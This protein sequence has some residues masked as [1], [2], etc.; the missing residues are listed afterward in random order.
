M[1]SLPLDD[2]ART[3][4]DHRGWCAFVP[5]QPDA[6]LHP[7]MTVRSIIREATLI[8]GVEA[9]DYDELVG[10]LGLPTDVLHRRP[11]QLSG[12]QRQRVAL[13]RLFLRNPELILLD[14]PLEGLDQVT[15]RKL[16]N[17]ILAFTKEKTVL[18]ITHQLEGLELMNRILFMEKG[19]IVE[20]G[21]FSE[22]I[23]K[24][25][26]FYAYCRLTMASV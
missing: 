3:A 26:R 10:S 16:H 18:Y 25:G 9:P 23:A 19:R 7:L 12:G 1:G 17:D 6:T 8:A 24:K 14:E 22:L 21:T 4:P 2:G 5:Q 11:H 13:A 20:D 15:R